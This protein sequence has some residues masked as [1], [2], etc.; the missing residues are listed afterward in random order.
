MK[1][2]RESKVIGNTLKS[3]EQIQKIVEEMGSTEFKGK[4]YHL[5]RKNCNHLNRNMIVKNMYLLYFLSNGQ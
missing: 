1:F 2:Q 5:I 4:N 3:E